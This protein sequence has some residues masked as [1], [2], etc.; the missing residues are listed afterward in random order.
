MKHKLSKSYKNPAVATQTGKVINAFRAND[1][2]K[3][4]TSVV[5]THGKRFIKSDKDIAGKSLVKSGSDPGINIHFRG[6]GNEQAGEDF[7][8]WSAGCTVLR[9]ALFSKR[10]GRFIEIVHKSKKPR[11]YLVV[12]SQYV[13][14]YHEWVDYCKGDKQKAQDPK[15]VLKEDVLKERQ[16]NGKYVPSIIDPAYAKANPTKVDPALFSVAQ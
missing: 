11:P 9:H 3:S 16:V 4:V 12:S 15:S 14:L 7:G 5:R 13:R 2:G 10:Y 8:G 1:K 6:Y